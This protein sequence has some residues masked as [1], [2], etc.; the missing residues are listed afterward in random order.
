VYERARKKPKSKRLLSECY[1]HFGLGTNM[2]QPSKPSPAPL[3]ADGTLR[4]HVFPSHSL[5]AD[6]TINLI[7][8]AQANALRRHYR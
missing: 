7:I 5:L 6:Y 3:L 2:T 1:N 4:L 8:S